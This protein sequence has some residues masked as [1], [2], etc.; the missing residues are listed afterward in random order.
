MTSKT[1]LR[2]RPKSFDGKAAAKNTIRSLDGALDVL[3]ILSDSDGMTLTELSVKLS[4]SPSTIYRI[5]NT[6][7][8]RSIVEIDAVQT[9]HVGPAAFR[10]G[11]SFLR[12]SSILERSRPVMRS[13]MEEIGET[14]NL[15]IERSNSVLFISQVECQ[16][17][18][19]A[20][21]PPGTQSPM[22][23]SGIGKALLSLFPQDR[24]DKML[25]RQTLE[26]FTDRTI[27]D[28]DVLRRDLK[29]I[30]EM[31]FALDN[32]ERTVG[33]RCIA[34]PII[35]LHGE[36]VA[37]ISVSGPTNRMTESRLEQISQLVRE[38]AD[39]LSQSLGT[40]HKTKIT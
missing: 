35:D 29:G 6:F 32:E 18:I 40:A 33:M 4:R 8:K 31:G 20:F 12:R 2:G 11:S 5:L 37:G 17:T 15:G 39:T 16:E 23:A 36:A 9:W 38:A 10:L 21:F 7:A 14:A 26:K 19:R 13:L 27:T 24:L 22:H 25:R 30:R 3:D 1:R 34:A 28:A